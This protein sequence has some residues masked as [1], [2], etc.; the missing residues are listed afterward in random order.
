[1]TWI[2]EGQMPATSGDY[3]E[4]LVAL[5]RT[6]VELSAAARDGQ[7]D[8]VIALAYAVEVLS[9]DLRARARVQHFSP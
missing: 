4:V 3:S 1:M 6:A 5:R 9:R 8:Q 2:P 7:H